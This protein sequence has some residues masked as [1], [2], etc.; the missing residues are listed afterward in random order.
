MK[1]MNNEKDTQGSPPEEPFVRLI[2]TVFLFI[3]TYYPEFNEVLE[4][5]GLNYSQYV[6]LLTLF[7]HG[8]LAEGEL[9][10]MLHLNPSTMSRMIYALEE[11]GWVRCV[12]DPS[13]RRRVMVSF[14]PRGK[15][16]IEGMMRE[17]A[18]VLVRLTKD[19]NEEE[20]KRVYEMVDSINRV[21]WLFI[22]ARES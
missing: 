10:R 6:A 22:G 1:N 4:R 8:S 12:R 9:A 16:R 2:E 17:P 3:R 15:K 7:M 21:L 18:R 13:D 11:R 5:Y 19:L 14:T 20:R